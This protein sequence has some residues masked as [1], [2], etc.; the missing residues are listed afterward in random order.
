M[1]KLRSARR[2]AEFSTT[3]TLTSPN[4]I[5][6]FQ[7]GRDMLL[8]PKTPTLAGS[9]T[10]A[11]EILASEGRLWCFPWKGTAFF[12]GNRQ[13]AMLATAVPGMAKKSSKQLLGR[14]ERLFA[15]SM[16]SLEDLG[17][18]SVK[19]G[20][21]QARMDVILSADSGRV[22]QYVGDR[23]YYGFCDSL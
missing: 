6:P 4:E 5:C 22:A 16:E 8:A 19:I 3:G 20:I 14:G 1:R 17:K 12:Q 11:T 9:R 21:D 10:E 18:L 2:S 7:I 15:R 13:L 23:P